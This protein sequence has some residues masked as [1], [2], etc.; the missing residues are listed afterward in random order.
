MSISWNAVALKAPY[1][2]LIP[3]SLVL[4]S[5]LDSDIIMAAVYPYTERDGVWPQK[6]GSM[7]SFYLTLA[8]PEG[9]PVHWMI[10]CCVSTACRGSNSVDIEKAVRQAWRY[11]RRKFLNIATVIEP[12]T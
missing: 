12:S 11:T 2:D 7:E 1:F 8:S 5:L 4:I 3:L 6:L 9:E 10:G